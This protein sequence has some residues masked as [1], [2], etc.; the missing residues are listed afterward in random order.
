MAWDF[1][2]VPASFGTAFGFGGSSQPQLVKSH[3][4][5]PHLQDYDHGFSQTKI[6]GDLSEVLS[7]RESPSCMLQV[8]P[9]DFRFGDTPIS[10]NLHM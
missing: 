2:P 3:V 10:G 4:Q 5:Y 6:C 7:A 9:K 8:G 1:L